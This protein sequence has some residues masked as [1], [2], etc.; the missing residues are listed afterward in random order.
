MILYE[1]QVKKGDDWESLTSPSRQGI[2]YQYADRQLAVD[3]IDLY[4]HY[5]VYGQDVQIKEVEA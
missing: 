1:V 5:A 4:Y 2:P 3:I